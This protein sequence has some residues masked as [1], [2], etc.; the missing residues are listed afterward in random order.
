MTVKATGYVDAS[1]DATITWQAG[2]AC[3]EPEANRV[4]GTQMVVLENINEAVPL[5]ARQHHCE[6]Q[7]QGR[8]I[9]AACDATD[10]RSSSPAAESRR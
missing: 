4:Y 7:G 2:F 8:R 1:G 6:A 9:W 10:L 3:R 5:D